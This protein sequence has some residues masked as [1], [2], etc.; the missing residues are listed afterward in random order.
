MPKRVENAR[1]AVLDTGIEIEKTQVKSTLKIKS[2]ELLAEAR[3]EESKLVEERVEALA[4]TGVNVVFTEKGIDDHGMHFLAKKGIL[5]VRRCNDGEIKKIVKATGHELFQKWT[6]LD[7]RTLEKQ[8]LLKNVVLA[9]IK[10]SM[11]KDA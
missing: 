9:I 3:L 4:A 2:P 8:R 7:L 10:C 5:A 6:G 11:W 1:I